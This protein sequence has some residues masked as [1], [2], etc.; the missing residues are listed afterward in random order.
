MFLRNIEGRVGFKLHEL[1]H[2]IWDLTCHDKEVNIVNYLKAHN[3]IDGNGKVIDDHYGMANMVECELDNC[4]GITRN[5][6][7]FV[8]YEGAKKLVKELVYE[9]DNCFAVRKA[10]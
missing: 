7:I 1:S 9:T 8:S 10:E 5:E 2:I 6:F 4:C 3:V